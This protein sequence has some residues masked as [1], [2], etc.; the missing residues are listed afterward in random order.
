MFVEC[1]FCHQQVP[2]SQYAAH[3]QQH[4]QLLPD[5][6]MQDHINLR[7]EERYR[8]S[9]ANVPQDYEH[10]ACGGVTR[11]PEEVIRSYLADPFLYND[12]SFCTG[13]NRYVPTQELFW[14]ETGE[15]VFRYNQNLRRDYLLKQG[16]PPQEIRYAANGTVLKPKKSGSS[17]GCIVAAILSVVLLLGAGG[18]VAVAGLFWFLARPN[19]RP[20]PVF[21]APPAPAI[22]P[23]AA[24]FED[25]Q[26]QMRR[27]QEEHRKM[28]DD[29]QRRHEEMRK[30][31]HE[32]AQ[33]GF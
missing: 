30:R 21:A 12:H 8:G 23:H 32:Q 2:K 16:V 3:E 4:T 11:M 24:P 10:Q 19:P 28:F 13:C 33:P 6:Q 26:D 14:I 29:M 25:L 17:A 31:L 7:Q 22:L 15:Q 20:A 18:I 27:Q 5:G 9:L 1:P